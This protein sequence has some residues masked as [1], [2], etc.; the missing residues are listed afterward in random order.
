M[1]NADKFFSSL[2]SLYFSGVF[3]LS[4]IDEPIELILD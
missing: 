2:T 1:K 4:H 3:T